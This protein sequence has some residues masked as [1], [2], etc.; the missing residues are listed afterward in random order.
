MVT[1]RGPGLQ[2]QHA[3]EERLDEPRHFQFAGRR[4]ISPAPGICSCRGEKSG[5]IV[6]PFSHHFCQQQLVPLLVGC[7]LELRKHRKLRHSG[8]R[9][10]AR[11]FAILQQHHIAQL[12]AGRGTKCSLPVGGPEIRRAAQCLLGPIV[13]VIPERR[14]DMRFEFDGGHQLAV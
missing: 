11:A 13:E 3:A 4:P 9:W 7:P 1:E 8:A 12:R 6:Q 14:T 10:R 2:R 5:G